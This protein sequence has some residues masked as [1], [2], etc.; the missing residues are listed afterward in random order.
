VK[1]LAGVTRCAAAAESAHQGPWVLLLSNVRK[2]PNLFFLP[3]LGA[4]VQRG[5]FLIVR[6][7]PSALSFSVCIPISSSSLTSQLI[8]PN[9][10]SWAQAKLDQPTRAL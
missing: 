4:L 9:A 1:R 5:F 10:S 8:A 3:Q 7:S 6:K 2:L